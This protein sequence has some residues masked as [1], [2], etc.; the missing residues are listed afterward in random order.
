M[1][2]GTGFEVRLIRTKFQL[3][4]LIPVWPWASCSTSLDVSF[5]LC[6][7]VIWMVAI[8]EEFLKD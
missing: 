1:A 2:K 6:K 3:H 4:P 7:M 8:S 5:L